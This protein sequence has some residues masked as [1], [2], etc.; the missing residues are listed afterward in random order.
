MSKRILSA[1]MA[2]C[3][4]LALLAALASP[5][6]ASE[7]PAGTS[8]AWDGFPAAEALDP[9]AVNTYAPSG[10]W[11]FETAPLGTTGFV[12]MQSV[13]RIDTYGAQFS[14]SSNIASAGAPQWGG[15]AN[16]LDTR[17][18]FLGDALSAFAYTA[19]AEGTVELG[20]AAPVAV[21][22]AGNGVNIAV[23]KSNAAGAAVR[24]WPA[25]NEWQ[26]LGGE[27]G[28]LGTQALPYGFEPIQI[29]IHAG[30][31]VYFVMEPNGDAADDYM[32]WE[33]T[34][35]YLNG[36]YDAAKDPAAEPEPET[37]QGPAE[38]EASSAWEHFP[39]TEALSRTQPNDYVPEA[40]WSFETAPL[41]TTAFVPMQDIYYINTYGA[42]FSI[43]S[44]ITAV[45]AP[46]WA[47]YANFLD[48]RRVFLSDSLNAFV[49][50]SPKAGTV[51]LGAE[52]PITVDAWEG[53]PNGVN[54]A[55]Y[56]SNASGTVIPIWPAGSRWQHLGGSEGALGTEGQPYMFEP[57]QL[58]IQA[59]E[60]IYFVMDPNG[61]AADDN[62]S[63]EPTVRHVNDVYDAADDPALTL[64]EP[65]EAAGVFPYDGHENTYEHGNG[66]RLDAAQGN[67]Y[68]PMDWQEWNGAWTTTY[69]A[70]DHGGDRADQW[71]CGVIF[72]NC[73]GDDA[74]WHNE[75]MYMSPAAGGKDVA[76][77]YRAPSEG[78]LK[79]TLDAGFYA[80][81]DDTS[82]GVSVWKNDVQIWPDAGAFTASRAPGT[83]EMAPLPIDDIVTAVRAGDVLHIRASA[84]NPSSYYELKMMPSAAYTSLE[85]DEAL[86]REHQF[87]A[88]ANYSFTGQFSGTQGKDGWHYLYA[89]IG[90]NDVTQLPALVDGWA[91]C[92]GLEEYNIAQIYQGEVL[93][94]NMYDAIIAFKAPYTGTVT[95]FM[96]DGMWLKSSSGEDA[97]DGC[98][99]GVQFSSDGEVSE[100][101]PMAY[102]PNGG[103]FDMEPITMEIKKNEYIYFRVN[104]GAAH[105]WHDSLHITP[106][107]R[108]SAI[109]FDDPGIVEDVDPSLR[110][111][112]EAGSTLEQGEFPLAARSY[113]GA[114]EFSVTAEALAEAIKTGALTE[115]AVYNVTDHAGLWLGGIA[116]ETVYDL[117][118]ICI[119]IA[120]S[121]YNRRE[122]PYAGED[123]DGRFAMAL[124]GNSA[125]VTLKNFALEVG[126]YTKEG[127]EADAKAPEAAVNLYDCA[128]VILENVQ[129]AGMAGM[130][131]GAL[132]SQP[133]AQ[134]DIRGSRID[135]AFENGAVF[136]KGGASACAT[137]AQSCILNSAGPAVWD[138]QSSGCLVA[139]SSLSAETAVLAESSGAIVQNNTIAGAV[140]LEQGLENVL[141]ALNTVEGDI[142]AEKASNLVLL[143]NTAQNI[144]VRTSVNV[145]FAQNRVSG[146]VETADNDYQLMQGNSFAACS[147]SGSSN[148]FGDDVLDP[149]ARSGNGVNEELLPKTNFEPFVGMEHKAAV[150]TADGELQLQRY[151]NLAARTQTYVIVP[152]GLYTANR[153]A[154]AGL[155][156]YDVYAY[157]AM[158]EFEEYSGNVLTLTNCE[159]VSIY[160]LIVS[161]ETNANGQATIIEKTDGYVIAQ[162]DPGYLPDLTDPA[163]YPSDPYV[164][165]FRP[166]STVPFADISFAGITYLGDGKHKCELNDDRGQE[167]EVGGKITMR[168]AGT[169]VVV[170]TG[171]GGVRFEDFSIISGAGFGFQERNGAGG[172]ELYRVAI[173][174]KAAPLLEGTAEDYA[175]YSNGLVWTDEKGRLRGPE[176]YL[177]TCDATHSTNMRKGPAVVN[178]LFERM[179]DDATNISGEFGKVTA[180]DAAARRLTYTLGDN[181]YQ[182][183]PANFRAGDTALLFTRAGEL[184]AEAVVTEEPVSAGYQ[185][186]TL[187]LD[188][189]VEIKSGTLIENASANGAGFVFDNCLV[190]TTRSR[191]FLL[192]ASD[193]QIKNCTIRNV[194]MA[195]ILVKPEIDE[196]WNECGYVQNLEI[197]NNVFENTGF[198]NDSLKSTPV[199]ICG[200]GQFT[201]EPA[202]LMHRDILIQ[203]NVFRARNA[204]NALYIN[205]AQ[206]V[207]V[208]GNDFGA[209]KGGVQGGGASPGVFIDGAY[210]IEVSNNIYPSETVQKVRLSAKTRRIYG[211]DVGYALGDYVQVDFGSVYTEDGCKITV[212]VKNVSEKQQ[213]YALELNGATTP[214]LLSDGLAFLDITLGAGESRTLYLDVATQPG[215]MEPPQVF[216]TVGLDISVKGVTDGN[217]E[218]EAS[219]NAALH[220]DTAGAVEWADMPVISKALKR[221]DGTD[222]AASARFAW[223]ASNLYMKV[224][225]QD[226][227]HFVDCGTDLLWDYDSLQLAFDPGREEGAG[228]AGQNEMTIGLHGNGTTMMY[229]NSDSITGKGARDL[230]GEM[231]AEITRDDAA[232]V[233][234]YELTLPWALIGK[235][236][237]APS[238]DSTIGFNI[239]VN[240]RDQ[241]DVPPIWC[242]YYMEF[243]GGIAENKQAANFGPLLLVGDLT[244]LQETDMGSLESA[245]KA[246]DGVDES[247]YTQASVEAMRRAAETARKM[248]EGL[249]LPNDQPSAD[250]VV[251]ALKAAM[252]GLEK[253]ADQPDYSLVVAG[254]TG[255]GRY[256]PGS[257]VKAAAAVPQGSRFVR[258]EATGIALTG[259]DI[260]ANPVV[261]LMP[262][263][264]V[265]LTAVL[266]KIAGTEEPEAGAKAEPGPRGNTGESTIAGIAFEEEELMLKMGDTQRLVLSALPDGAPMP[267]VSYVSSDPLIVQ[268][269]EDGNITAVGTGTATVTA[270]AEKGG[271]TAVC[272]IT[273]VDDPAPQKAVD[274]H[275]DASKEESRE[276]FS[277]A[278]SA[279][280]NAVGTS[281]PSA[282][283]VPLLVLLAA[284]LLVALCLLIWSAYRRARK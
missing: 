71:A 38:Q 48:T 129:I 182:G 90:E 135:G 195:A 160:G 68:F 234:C 143:F 81:A 102:I 164:E 131:V 127:Q 4:S 224:D 174:P 139:E 236:G 163:Y 17:W 96:E 169:S 239:C 138:V 72:A 279:A 222:I 162:T 274:A 20:A 242:R 168:G 144:R 268:V 53:G 278:P 207:R 218:G 146:A 82:M 30:E 241:N 191:G 272:T 150:K 175:G 79:L 69:W 107:V 136:F 2:F 281:V 103:A 67:A 12:P 118:N 91:W 7:V 24:I 113:A 58:S 225:V 62:M 111:E 60:K 123:G 126:V 183:L 93:P 161:H 205:G 193:G 270:T 188:R 137:V 217:V 209:R 265:T 37:E 247:L 261:F 122:W 108:Y 237:G 204:E 284:F 88:K 197:L 170:L 40:P 134:L 18:V 254:G 232:R 46:Q 11:A 246:V 185:V 179:T 245:L 214:G 109:D 140:Q 256:K 56:K 181:F 212:T 117:K 28:A 106:A 250:S 42:Q 156:G 165:A 171:S 154:L 155:K 173:T 132:E 199:A 275:S 184:L 252:D 52:R 124:E 235:N 263:N 159:D 101:R 194:G 92:A 158:I 231:D 29:S 49:Y 267:R 157:G 266:G 178:C 177:S 35:T 51:E 3:M 219:F 186:Y 13:Y 211:T 276:A 54:I 196:V 223:D 189:D 110:Q 41:N 153:L 198:Y 70:Y 130:G 148:V 27:E 238:A 273:V 282:L 210:D 229:M 6:S 167:L 97:G 76:F 84:L 77:S 89:P 258:W 251:Q 151:L 220:T 176:P 104:R 145:T 200:D 202:F 128:D 147:D 192:K 66:L 31:R 100:L 47:G 33:P 99:F 15:Y 190:D 257:T 87:N 187:T 221:E 105:N 32:T 23:Y 59:G 125:P 255:N 43:S 149:S 226:D 259:A 16:F 271:S 95:A 80:E 8:N 228:T 230:T 64:P 121:G 19:P 75:G 83:S 112:P 50:T 280:E 262:E 142:C 98:N 120:P 264:D 133:A 243:Y 5:V 74:G 141:V 249:L 269:D 248:L 213:T 215:E 216:G 201:T 25:E 61:N 203:N 73:W 244:K 166:G 63:W 10:P 34:V 94:G 14:V 39:A 180:Y 44:N 208:L 277:P 22:T 172:T 260:T 233:T 85:Y 9:D 283:R 206:A 115:G 86:D 240:D 21:D 152:P 253:L 45:G 26:L 116:E 114:Q 119:R 227:V 57:F 55:V 1:F 78:V 65:S 36:E